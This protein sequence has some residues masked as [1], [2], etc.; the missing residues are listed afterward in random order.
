MIVPTRATY[1]LPHMTDRRPLLSSMDDDYASYAVSQR[2]A[3][4]R[5]F[6]VV[7]A[8]AADMAKQFL[9]EQRMSPAERQAMEKIRK[10]QY[11][12]EEMA[13]RMQQHQQQSQQNGA[14]QHQQQLLQKF[15]VLE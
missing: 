3:F 11:E 8:A 12:N 7:M 1:P 4:E 6:P 15:P 2:M 5:T 13:A 10:L 14:Q 9:A